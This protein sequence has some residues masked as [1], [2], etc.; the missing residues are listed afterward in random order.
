MHCLASLA[1]ALL[2]LEAALALAP[3]PALTLPGQAVC[4]ELSSSEEDVC[5]VSCNSDENCPQGTKCCPRSSCVVPLIAPVRRAGRCPLVQAPR[6]PQPCLESSECS[7]NDQ[8]ADHRK[9]CLSI[10]TL[11]CLEPEAGER[12]TASPDSAPATATATDAAEGLG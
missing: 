2:A 9:C 3:A 5:V 6:I 12:P 8:C 1:L 10:C 11:R 4:P 7:R